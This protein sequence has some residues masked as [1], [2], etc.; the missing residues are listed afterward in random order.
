MSN[1]SHGVLITCPPYRSV[2]VRWPGSEQSQGRWK[3]DRP[4]DKLASK[5]SSLMANRHCSCDTRG[6]QLTP[7][8]AKTA[9]AVN[10]GQPG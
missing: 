9:M 2:G 6:P 4:F 1:C 5:N 10:A 3:V 7:I 8:Q